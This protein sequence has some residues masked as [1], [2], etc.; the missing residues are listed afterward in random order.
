MKLAHFLTSSFLLFCSVAAAQTASITG[1]VS[2]SSGAVIAS[3]SVTAKS[4]STG[5]EG[6][7]K[8]NSEG[9]YS[10]LQLAPGAYSLT[11]EM[12]GFKTV[13][14]KNLVLT[15][16]QAARVNYS[17]EVGSVADSVEVSDRAILLDSESATLG[18]VIG[19]KQVTELP[20]LGRNSYALAML[21]PGVRPS[22]GVNNLVIDQISTVAYSINGQRANSN[23][24]LLDGAPNAAAAQNQPVINANPD[25]VQEFKVETNSYSAEYGR[26]AGGVFNVVTR[27]GSNDLHFTAYEFLR[28]DKLNANDWFA[29]RNGLARPPFKFNQFGGS[30]GGPVRIPK[31]YDGRNRTFFFFNTEIVRFI[32]GIT[33]TASL[34]DPQMLT[35]NFS[36]V[37][38]TNGAAVT[39]YDP[40]TTVQTGSGFTRSPF[41]NNIIPG[42]R[43]NPVARNIA[44][45]FPSP[46]TLGA[47]YG[48]IN[49]TR[50]DGN[51]VNKNSFSPRIDHNF[52]DRNRMFFRYSYDDT[53]FNRAPVYGQNYLNIAPTA[54]PQTF[55]RWNTVLEDSHT[56]SP[57]ML[58]TLRYSATRLINFRRPYSDNFDI[59]SLGL[60]S[61]MRQGMVDPISMPAI[62]INGLSVSSSVP[63]IIVGGLIG[64]TDYINFGN[65]QQNIQGNITKTVGK[66][67][68]KFGGEYRVVQFNNLQ[69]G[70]QATNFSFGPN[71]TQGPNPS[72]PASNTGL[73]LAAFLLGIPGGSVSPVPALAQTNKYTAAFFQDTWKLTSAV[74]LNLGLRYD[75]ETPRTDRFNQLTNFDYNVASPLKIDGYDLRGGLV[76]PGSDGRSRYNARPD[77]NNVAP[78]AG[79]A[80]RLTPK[81]VIRAGGGL[82]YAATTG[83]G[84]GTGPFGISG[85]QASTSIVTSL[86]GVT[87]IVSLSNPYPNGFNSPTG[88]S[89][90]LSTLLGQS[91]QFVDYGNYTPYSA[92]WSFGIQQELPGRVLL[93]LGYAGSRGLG[94]YENRQWNQLDPSLLSQG[95]A[96]RQQVAN[97]FFGQIQVG[98]LANRTIAK[99]QLLRPYPQ[100]DAVSSQN[101]SWATSRY[102]ALEVRAEKRYSS[103][104]NLSFSYTWSKLLDYGVGSFAG[105]NLGGSGV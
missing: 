92:Q 5:V 74:T 37:S 41:P 21:V 14:E 66:H 56:F 90:G 64:A 13:V 71:F 105:E 104:L 58:M 42:D 35:G 78:R 94:Q 77:R 81:T 61:Y 47:S 38:Q 76:F 3:A 72:S 12:T 83:L 22:S 62:T 102:H 85:Y 39:I 34:P 11:V 87:P 46:T 36:N 93:E 50:T 88:S 6:R 2:D 91:I 49:Y 30:I 86:D 8:T 89:A 25:M 27:S 17:L 57:T 65:T 67:T 82:F 9:Y 55:T 80:W 15:V 95:D 40:N 19:S 33:F 68:L 26:A 84:G 75:Y 79:I 59:E 1:L 45:L 53:P 23:E 73:G 7:T 60:P 98:T 99:A 69:V 52:N 48:V 24:F 44:S 54:G 31:L 103:G 63:N 97:P 20:L 51:I 28:N 32:Q 29:N 70:D 96:L 101:A 43:I 4:E 18:A 100:Y 10:L 16:G